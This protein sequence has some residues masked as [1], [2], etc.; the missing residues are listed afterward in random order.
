[1][2]EWLIMNDEWMNNEWIM[3]WMNWMEWMNDE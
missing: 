1:M 3:D 2:N